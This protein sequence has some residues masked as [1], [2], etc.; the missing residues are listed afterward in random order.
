MRALLRSLSIALFMVLPLAGCPGTAEP[1]DPR[2]TAWAEEVDTCAR[3][4][5]AAEYNLA[6]GA[7]QRV[8]DDPDLDR[9]D[10]LVVDQARFCYTTART[11][12][13][14]D[15]L[16]ERMEDLLG[17]I[18]DLVAGE[19]GGFLSP[20]DIAYELHAQYEP[21]LIESFLFSFLSR[22]ETSFEVNA[23]QL[24]QIIAKDRFE[25]SLGRLPVT[26]AGQELLDAGGHYDMAEVHILYGLTRT[27]SATF[28]VLRAINFSFQLS[29]VTQYVL[30]D[31]ETPL[32]DFADFPVTA[33]MNVAS[34][35][36]AGNPSFLTLKG[37]GASQM[38]SAGHGYAAGWD[39]ILKAVRHMRH[40]RT[41]DQSKYLI[42]YMR[43]D[44]DQDVFIL[45]LSFEASPI[46]FVDL[47]RLDDL[48]IPLS[49][50]I[51]ESMEIMR[52]NFAG[53]SGAHMVSLQEDVFP[54]IALMT[55]VLLQTGMFDALINTA[56]AEF[57]ESSGDQIKSV[58]DMFG[59]NPAIV[60]GILDT[61]MPVGM[62]FDFGNMFHAAMGPRHILPAW[63]EPTQAEKD[64]WTDAGQPMARAFTVATFV[65]SY[66]CSN[67]ERP[68]DGVGDGDDKVEGYLCESATD[69]THF[70]DLDP[71]GSDRWRN[72]TTTANFERSAGGWEGEIPQDG[73]NSVLPYIGFKDASFGGVLY[74]DWTNIANAD[75]MPAP[76]E[77]ERF[78]PATQQTLNA[79]IAAIFDAVGGFF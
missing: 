72:N 29:S 37:D 14:V 10:H 52:D 55:T 58:I 54:M 19:D 4:L 45:H 40:V 6:R 68:I 61:F 8:V 15:E 57:D 1:E 77:N 67:G 39:G 23:A 50:N 35:F 3:Y 2:V 70:Q 73:I 21:Q 22:L 44:D 30:G 47:Q 64:A 48:E 34:V 62:E 60:R 7:A 18:L 25:W 59:G 53:V 11:L 32:D 63:F 69:G 12:A 13:N 51:M 65:L 27:I 33:I 24:E 74:L 17:F 38:E 9:V 5:S 66:E 79:T 56:L 16:A 28:S 78:Q 76:P 71:E 41:G 75:H 36:L 26:L 20:H 49:E 31:Y 43:N 42:E 46:P